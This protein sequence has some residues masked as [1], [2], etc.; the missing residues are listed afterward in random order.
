MKTL[1]I[2]MVVQIFKQNVQKS[3]L[4]VPKMEPKC[5][6]HF[7]IKILHDYEINQLLKSIFCSVSRIR[8]RKRFALTSFIAKRWEAQVYS[9]W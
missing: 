2:S 9:L 1:F 4:K 8:Y 3:N 6:L 7:I 5:V